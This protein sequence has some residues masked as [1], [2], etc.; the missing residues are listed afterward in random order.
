MNPMK[1]TGGVIYGLVHNYPQIAM[2]AVPIAIAVG[3]ISCF[4]CEHMVEAV[5]KAIISGVI[6]FISLRM[7]PKMMANDPQWWKI[8]LV[9]LPLGFL[10]GMGVGSLLGGACRLAWEPVI[11]NDDNANP[12]K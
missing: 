8:A 6:V 11:R 4:A 10:G 7:A 12:G 9:S 1:I 3:A 5:F 2:I